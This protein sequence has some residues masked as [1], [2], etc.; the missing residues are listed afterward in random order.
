MA[1]KILGRYIISDPTI[2]HGAA[3]FRGTRI[4]VKDVLEQVENGM[5]WEAITEEW[6]GTITRDAIAEAIRLP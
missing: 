5:A 4:L 6:R 2:C 1:A 3:T